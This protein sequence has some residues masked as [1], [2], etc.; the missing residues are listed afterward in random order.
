[1][2]AP[3]RRPEPVGFEGFADFVERRPN[4]ERWALIEGA[5]VGTASGMQVHA[6]IIVNLA[7]GLN[8]PLRARGCLTLGEMLVRNAGED[9]H[10]CAPDIL[11]RCGPIKP[12]RW[13]TDPM[14]IVEVL[15]P[16][17]V[18]FDR[19]R[20][21]DFYERVPSLRHIALVY[22]DM[23]WIE[24]YVR[25]GDARVLAIHHRPA[26]SL[27]LEAVDLAVTL[28]AICDGVAFE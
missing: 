27:R 20:K 5:L 26:D 10:A 14:A 15:S 28:A 3:M 2:N 25:D 8:G 19:G 18:D 11:V 4:H 12:L 24:A 9:D 23:M 21:L 6:R 13:V 16:S 7:A 17:T 1:M 22:Q